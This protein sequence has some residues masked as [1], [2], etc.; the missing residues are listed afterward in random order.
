MSKKILCLPG[1]LQSGKVFAEKSSALRKLL[2]KLYTLDYVDPALV[3]DKREYL[4]FSLGATD[5]EDASKWDALV[6]QNVNRCWY[7]YEN[8]IYIDFEE[9]LASVVRYIKENGPYHGIIG[10]SQ[11]ASMAMILTTQMKKLVP[12]N[13]PIEVAVIISGFAFTKSKKDNPHDIEDLEEYTKW[14]GPHPTYES[15]FVPPANFTTKVFFIY[16]S[17]DG[18]VP[19]VRSKYLASHFDGVNIEHEGGHFVPNK[20]LILKPIVEQIKEIMDGKPNL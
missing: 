7:R 9:S 2:S 17:G 8:G 1:F 5:E 6:L 12:E 19:A 14:I 13:P 3:I 4:P 15:Y 16:G 11:G 20:K 10:F 18:V